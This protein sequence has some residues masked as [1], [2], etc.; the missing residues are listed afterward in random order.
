M[1]KV[2]K[3]SIFIGVLLAFSLSLFSQQYVPVDSLFRSEM[4]S[5][6]S[7]ADRRYELGSDFT[8]LA[9][10]FITKARLFSHI[11]EG[12]EHIVRLWRLDGG[13]YTLV[14]GPYSWNFSAGIQGWRDFTFPSPVEVQANTTYIISIS[15]GPDLNYMKS[16]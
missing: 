5:A 12:G 9:D 3:A 10:G 4:P 11:N 13:S 16:T 14:A 8:T 6:S 15:N 2:R 7:S 1:E